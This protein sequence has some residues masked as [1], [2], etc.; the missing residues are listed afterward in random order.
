MLGEGPHILIMSKILCEYLEKESGDRKIS[1]TQDAQEVNPVLQATWFTRYHRV[2]CREDSE[3]D[4]CPGTN[5]GH[6][7]SEVLHC[8]GGVHE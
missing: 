2:A 6:Y 1:D 5:L 4:L 7:T 3:A 8:L